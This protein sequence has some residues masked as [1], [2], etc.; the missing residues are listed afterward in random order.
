[1]RPRHISTYGR[2][3]VIRLALLTTDNREHFK[4]YTNP[5]PYFGT[6]PEALLEGFKALPRE[7][8]VHVISCLQQV[9]VSSPNRLAENIFY[10]ALHVNNIG[11]MK[12][13]YIGCTIA[14]RRKLQEIKPDVVHG[15]GTERDCAITAVRSGYSNVLTI[16]GNMRLIAAFLK[17]K[18]F[19]YYWLATRLEGYCLGK[20][21]GVVAISNYTRANV[22]SSTRKT[23]LLHNAVHPSYFALQRI[24]ESPPKVLCVAQVGVRK[25]QIQLMNSLDF[26]AR[27]QAFKLCFAGGGSEHDPYFRRF[28]GEVNRRPWCTYLGPLERAQLQTEMSKAS[29]LVLASLEDNCPMVIL[30]ASA[31]GLPVAASRVGGIPDLIRSGETGLLFDPGSNKEIGEAVRRI[32]SDRPFASQLSASA[33]AEATARFDPQVIAQGHLEIYREILKR[34]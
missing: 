13:G 15:Q 17:A 32:L 14:V 30:E 27:E 9:P 31:T 10:H 2:S 8:E 12:T 1:M 18:P 19:S 7:V 11:W 22:A 6:A 29:L 3:S 4:D 33:R 16:H 20:T 28:L 5:Q 23:W 21:A 24:P 25:N 34:I 26:L